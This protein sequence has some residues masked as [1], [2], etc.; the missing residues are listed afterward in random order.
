MIKKFYQSVNSMKFAIPMTSLAFLIFVE[1]FLMTMGKAVSKL[2]I[3]LIIT[4]VI[5]AVIMVFYYYNKIKVNTQLKKVNDLKAYED[6]GMIDR[7][8]ILEDRMLVC[9]GI[10]IEEVKTKDVVGAVLEEKA[11]GKYVM[12]LKDASHFIDMSLLD[13]EDGQKVAAYLKRVNPSVSLT[14]VE[15]KGQGTL[16][17]LGADV[18]YGNK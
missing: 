13:K 4:A 3:A 16:K 9:C 8:Y 10:K 11:H 15:P 12:H 5:L 18:H 2:Y 14:N 17:E 1:A 7:T 6:G